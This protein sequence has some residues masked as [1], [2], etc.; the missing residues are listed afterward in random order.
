MSLENL[1][2]NTAYVENLLQRGMEALNNGGDFTPFGVTPQLMLVGYIWDLVDLSDKAG[3][4]LDLTYETVNRLPVTMTYVYPYLLREEEM[5]PARARLD[6]AKK[7]ASY[8]MV[9]PAICMAVK[10]TFSDL[11]PESCKGKGNL[12]FG[13]IL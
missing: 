2:V 10:S 11:L 6:M 12:P 1:Q 9:W 3:G 8:L 5:L 4:G 13:R 7:L